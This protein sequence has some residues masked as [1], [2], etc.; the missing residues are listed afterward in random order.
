ML[1]CRRLLPTLH[2]NFFP[3]PILL[4]AERYTG[5]SVPL[6]IEILASGACKKVASGLGLG[7]GFRWVLQF[8][9]PVTMTKPQ[10]GRKSA[11]KQNYKFLH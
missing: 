10:N 5:E 4:P 1:P 9:P 6:N 2:S 7:G 8:P 3:P 11:E